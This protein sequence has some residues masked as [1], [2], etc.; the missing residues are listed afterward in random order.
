MKL[1]LILDRCCRGLLAEPVEFW[2]DIEVLLKVGECDGDADDD[3]VGVR[4]LVR[5]ERWEPDCIRC[6]R[7]GVR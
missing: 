6:W 3:D 5:P 2:E 4:D 1:T 7:K